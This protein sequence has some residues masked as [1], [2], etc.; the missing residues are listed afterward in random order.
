MTFS[1]AAFRRAPIAILTALVVIALAAT[2]AY[3]A[4]RSMA[5]VGSAFQVTGYAES[6]ATTSVQIAAS[7]KAMTQV[8]IDGVNLTPDGAGVGKPS[9]TTLKLLADA[10]AHDL[11]ASLL[12]GNYSDAIND[13]SDPLAE[14][15][16]RSP[17][18]IRSA[19]AALVTEVTSEGWDGVT[20]DL[21]SLNGF[22]EQGHTRD[23]NVGL[24]AFV[25]SLRTALGS[26]DLSICVS[27]TT[28]SY[29]D[30]G[31]NLPAL[32]AK[33]DD[34][35]LMAYDQH[36]P[37]WSKAGPVGGLPW[38]KK[39]L[40]GLMKG[41]P[42]AK[43]QLGVGE[44]G[45]SWPNHGTGT[46]YSVAAMRALV[47]KR[48]AHAIWSPAQREWHATFADGETVWWSDARSYAARLAL[49]HSKHLGGTAV[50]SLGDGDPLTAGR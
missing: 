28:G 20:I 24:V 17:A 10:H 40:A 3:L 15:M 13:F 42:A 34:V 50:W 7:A 46:N 36:G 23:D 41:V 19:V 43:I 45:Y 39:S 35:V 38:V 12:F 27:A 22:G 44:Y 37:A 30:L 25:T 49:A 26:R 14:K 29:A 32:S 47:L 2:G 8:G 18:N 6:G 31:Y 1:V 5:G 33:V 9:A 48:G 21:E 11:K 4:T 16:F